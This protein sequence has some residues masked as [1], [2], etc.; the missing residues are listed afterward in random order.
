MDKGLHKNSPFAY[1]SFSGCQELLWKKKYTGW[2]SLA[3]LFKLSKKAPLKINSD[4]EPEEAADGHSKWESQLCWS[5][6][7]SWS[8]S[9]KSTCGLLASCLEVLDGVYKLKSFIEEEDMKALILWKL[10]R[11]C[12]AEINHQYNRMQRVSYLRT[13]S[14]A[15]PQLSPFNVS[16]IANGVW[17]LMWLSRLY[18]KW[19]TTG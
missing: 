18:L 7:K 2:V 19:C 17:I 13:L 9:K 8:S 10:S 6:H 16:C 3:A 5:C 11:N 12:V 15:P 14:T 1:Y 4:I